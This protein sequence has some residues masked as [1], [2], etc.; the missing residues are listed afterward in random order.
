MAV[1]IF[2][3]SKVMSLILALSLP[4]LLFIKNGGL[5][6]LVAFLTSIYIFFADSLW[7]KINRI[8]Y[9]IIGGFFFYFAY[10][11]FVVIIFKSELRELDSVSRFLI[12]I[13][14]YLYSKNYKLEFN[15]LFYA[16]AFSASLIGINIL[17]KIFYNL[18]LF[19]EVHHTGIMSI[20][21]GI[22]FLFS[23]YIQG[24]TERIGGKILFASASLFSLL[25]M[26][27]YEGRGSWVAALLTIIVIF[28]F[29][30]NK[31]KI[32]SK[33]GLFVLPIALIF[34]LY[35]SNFLGFA[36]RINSIYH[37]TTGY[38]IE[39]NPQSSIGGR[40]EMWKAA[41]LMSKE[42][43]IVGI[44]VNNFNFELH[45]LIDQ[46]VISEHI[47]TYKHPHSEYL[48]NFI[49]KGIIG[50]LSLM[51]IFLLPLKYSLKSLKPVDSNNPI[52]SIMVLA[53]V[54]FYLVYGIVNGVFDHQ[55]TTLFFSVY[56]AIFIGL[57]F[58]ESSK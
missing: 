28:F 46:G 56:M 32:I 48:S 16:I 43:P 51:V 18:N 1:S 4:S 49:E 39:N 53:F 31:K 3:H 24:H 54:I 38:F 57:M 15:Y 25:G 7:R 36:N 52:F 50:L 13:P 55:I 37:D 30:K 40:L 33:I 6:I 23:F 26:S 58:Q 11:L 5:L 27:Y 21:S 22:L 45:K 44:G 17:T 9:L 8:D 42:N 2:S 29:E 47:S 10:T 14:L 41:L 34:T 12:F 19:Q 20:F 35:S